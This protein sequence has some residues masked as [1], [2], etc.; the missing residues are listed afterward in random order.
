MHI[1]TVPMVSEWC[2]I[3]NSI[4]GIIVLLN[5]RKR[6]RDEIRAKWNLS[7][8]Y[9]L[10]RSLQIE[11]SSCGRNPRRRTNTGKGYNTISLRILTGIGK[12]PSGSFQKRGGESTAGGEARGTVC[13][14]FKMSKTGI[15]TTQLLS[16]M[17]HLTLNQKM[18]W[19]TESSPFS[20]CVRI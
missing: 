3:P 16:E 14:L 1:F 13:S 9:R 18:S 10:D 7:I 4:W 19:V 11:E 2:L 5:E 15:Q 6:N 17:M 12:T 8:S 20:A